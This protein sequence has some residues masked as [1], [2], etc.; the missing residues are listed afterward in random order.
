MSLFFRNIPIQTIIHM[1]SSLCVL[2]GFL[3]NFSSLINS[4]ELYTKRGFSVCC[5]FIGAIALSSNLWIDMRIRYESSYLRCKNIY[6]LLYVIS[7][8]TSK[9]GFIFTIL[10]MIEEENVEAIRW[11][12]MSLYIWSTMTLFAHVGINMQIQINADDSL[13]RYRI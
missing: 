5:F 13:Q 11:V 8:I 9:F 2:V 3:L 1:V 4:E 7:I 6:I 10:S 12:Y